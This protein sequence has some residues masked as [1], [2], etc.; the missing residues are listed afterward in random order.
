MRARHR[1]GKFLLRREIYYQGPGEAWSR[2]HR[3]WLASLKFADRASQ[4]TMAD[5]LHAH[6]VL[7]ARR[8]RIEAELE[9]LAAS[10]PWT[11][12]IARLRC[13]CGIDTLS[14]LGLSPRSAS[15]TGSSIPTACPATSGS[16]P[17]EHHRLLP[18]P[19]PPRDRPS[20]RAPPARPVSPDHQHRLAR[21]AATARP[22]APAQTRTQE[23]QRRRRSRDRPRTRRL[24]LGDRARRLKTLT[25]NPWRAGEAVRAS[26]HRAQQQ[27]A[28][29]L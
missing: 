18:L 4:L 8:D 21:K 16:C 29:R 25:N 6:D 28:S 26:R 19:A 1:L 14:A 13:L 12:T 15:L 3:V 27:S 20:A 2:R 24:L 7:L 9:Q 11:A 22:L 5:Y 17:T 23:A 10:S